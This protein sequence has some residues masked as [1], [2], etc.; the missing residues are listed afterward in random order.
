MHNCRSLS[1]NSLTGT[2]PD[3]SALTNLRYMYAAL[4]PASIYGTSASSPSAMVPRPTTHPH[5]PLLVGPTS[6]APIVNRCRVPAASHDSVCIEWVMTGA[7][8]LL[9]SFYSHTGA[10]TPLDSSP[11]ALQKEWLGSGC[12]SFD[13]GRRKQSAGHCVIMCHCVSLCA[14]VCH[15]VSLCCSVSLC[16]AVCHHC[17]IV[18]HECHFVSHHVFLCVIL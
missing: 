8:H 10:Y 17:V 9:M 16:V 15:C 4:A 14:T 18:C 7:L 2:I 12:S 3:L 5:P 13:V 6:Q 1:N 11:T